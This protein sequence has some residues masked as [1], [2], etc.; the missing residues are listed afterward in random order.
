MV[1]PFDFSPSWFLTFST[2]RIAV[3]DDDP[4]QLALLV[5]TLTNQLALEDESIF[6]TPFQLG[7]ALRR[8]LRSETFDL[9]VL[10]WNV[11][12]LDG[13]ELLDWLRHQK[14]DEVPVI[15]LSSRASERDVAEALRMGADDYIVKPLRPI[16]LCAR[17]RRLLQ[18]RSPA[19]ADAIER[20]GT[21]AFDR[22]S[23]SASVTPSGEAAPTQQFT[24][25]DREYRLVLPL[26]RNA[27]KAVS[28]SYL[29]E[30]AGYHSEE[31]TGRLLDSHMYRLRNKLGLQSA[32]GVRLQTIYGQGYRLEM[33][34][35]Q[36]VTDTPKDDH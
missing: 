11:P 36:A 32:N 13:I 33:D 3:L 34:D 35:A 14:K 30:N 31:M 5:H 28:R 23:L 20:F 4:T 24:L 29:L 12:D 27:G 9:L 1:T 22:A 10:D 15:M 25:T 19:V 17:I 2:M 26:F 7:D 16:E 21:W 6:C 8:A 18:R